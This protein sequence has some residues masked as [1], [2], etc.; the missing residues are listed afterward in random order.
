MKPS[1]EQINEVLPQTQCG[2]C[3]Y[4]G[5]Q[6]YAQAIADK[7]AAINRCPPGGVRGLLALAALTGQTAEPYLADMEAKQKSRSRVQIREEDCI[8][9]TK[10]ITACP[11]DA[12]LGSSKY[13]HTVIAEECTG[14]DL[15]IAPCPVDCIDIIPLTDHDDIPVAEARKQSAYYRQRYE[16]REARLARDQALQQRKHQ[17]AKLGRQTATHHRQTIAARQQAIV[18]A[19]QRHKRKSS[20]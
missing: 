5:C 14:C 1:V 19:V 6:P 12:I 18:E 9:C 4:E 3:D 16:Q 7:K 20:S 10:C 13:M 8:G 2:L 15:C 17:Q 11:V